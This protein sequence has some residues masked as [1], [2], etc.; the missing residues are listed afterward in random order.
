MAGGVT[1]RDDL[2][3]YFAESAS[4]DRDRFV[5]ARRSKRLAWIVAAVASGL[6]ITAVAAVAMLTPLKTIAP[7]V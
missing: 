3:A 5:A 1:D 6:A 7:Y 4:W 2:K